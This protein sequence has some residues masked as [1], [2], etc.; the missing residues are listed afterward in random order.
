ME[1]ECDCSG[2]DCHLIGDDDSSPSINLCL[3][4]TLLDSYADGWNGAEWKF[5]DSSGGT[6]PTWNGTMSNTGY[7]ERSISVW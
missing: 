2:C 4:L 7:G 1:A 6:M 3:R 5:E